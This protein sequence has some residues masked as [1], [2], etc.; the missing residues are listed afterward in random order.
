MAKQQNLFC[1]ILKVWITVNI[2]GVK[3]YFNNLLPKLKNFVLK[4]FFL[5]QFIDFVCIL[6][7]QLTASV[8]AKDLK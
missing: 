3:R 5:K 6:N 7:I 8:K 4:H 1:F 2:K